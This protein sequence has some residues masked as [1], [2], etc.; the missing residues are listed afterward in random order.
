MLII[1]Q[2]LRLLKKYN[3]SIIL[4]DKILAV[5]PNYKLAYYN[6][7]L[8]IIYYVGKTLSSMD[9]VEESII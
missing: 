9:K 4:N 8:V 1:G 6:K 5:Y 2:S 3:E 7:G